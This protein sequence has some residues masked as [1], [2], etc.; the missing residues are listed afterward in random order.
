MYAKPKSFFPHKLQPG[1]T[2]RVFYMDPSAKDDGDLKDIR[3]SSMKETFF[4]GV[5][6]NF[7]GE[8]HARTMTLRAM[9][10]K[11]EKVMGMELQFP[12]H[13]PLVRRI[14]VLRRGYI[15]RNKNAYFIRG[16]IGKR[17][18]I[19][20][21]QE[22]TQVDE[23]YASLKEA[24]RA[25]EIPESEYPQQEWDRYPLPVWK[26]DQDEWD[27]EKYSPELVDKRNEY[28]RVVIAKYK[29]KIP[30]PSGKPGR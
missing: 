7:R 14:E 21:D 3:V 19:P 20:L 27:E 18:V 28:E 23:M 30:G 5:I 9:V 1:D 4:D 10:G 11:N 13:S 24:G 15:G 6:L 12:M 8:Y 16:M 2:V 25:D 17:N 22:R 29:K 26:Q